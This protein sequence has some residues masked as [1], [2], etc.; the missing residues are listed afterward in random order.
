MLNGKVYKVFGQ[1][2]LTERQF[3]KEL[4]FDFNALRPLEIEKRDK[5]IKQLFGQ[6]A[7]PFFIEPPF[8]C[9][10]VYNVSIGVNFYANYNLTILDCA[11]VTIGDNV[12]IPPNV[13]LFT[14]GHPIHFEQRNQ[15]FEYAIPSSIG[16]N[17]WIG[18]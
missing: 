18:V 5:I 7:E 13:T 17:V 3:A 6:I 9:D 1:E 12:F 10:Y 14:A 2:L 16:N 15:E 11:K 8:R 4:I